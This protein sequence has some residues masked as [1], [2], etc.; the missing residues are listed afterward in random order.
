[1]P[2][3]QPATRPLQGII[4]SETILTRKNADGAEPLFPPQRPSA[5]AIKADS[6][7]K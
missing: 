6:V 1:M 5:A 7:A 2:V 4:P 3:S